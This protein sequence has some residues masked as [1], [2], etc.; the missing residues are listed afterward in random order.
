MR[1][2]MNEY[3]NTKISYKLTLENEKMIWAIRMINKKKSGNH[4][5][6][7]IIMYIQIKTQA[8]TTNPCTCENNKNIDSS[9][10]NT[11]K[12]LFSSLS[13]I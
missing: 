5:D 6:N 10:I 7:D 9:R 3:D 13:Y 8:R 11:V 12:Y 4:N 1:L 2:K